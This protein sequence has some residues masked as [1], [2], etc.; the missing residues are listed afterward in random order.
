MTKG[1]KRY[2]DYISLIRRYDRDELLY[3]LSQSC[4]GW[5]GSPFEE[6]AETVA[7]EV[8]PWNVAGAAA[9]AITRGTRGGKRPTLTDVKRI[10]HEFSRIQTP[11]QL[12]E[13]QGTFGL[14]LRWAYEQWPYNRISK[15]D[16]ARCVALFVDTDLPI[17]YTPEAMKPGWQ[18]ELFGTTIETFVSVGAILW[19]ATNRGSR[20]PFPWSDEL[21]RMRDL[22]GGQK[23]FD[24]VVV[25]NFATDISG[26]KKARIAA[27]AQG[28][29][30]PGSQ[31]IREPFAYNPLLATPL[32]GGVLPGEWIAPCPPALNLKVSPAGIVYAGVAK[33]STG[34]FHDLGY[35]FEQYIG[36]QLRQGK[37]FVVRPEITYGKEEKKTI[38]WF[39]VTP[40]AVFLIECKSVLPSQA[41]KEGL[42]AHE[43]AHEQ[44][45]MKGVR[46]L[47]ATYSLVAKRHPA[48]QFLPRD[49]PI[50]GLLVTLGMFD[51][52]D[53]NFVKD[54]LPPADFP[55]AIVPS[56]FVESVATT[57][58]E[59]LAA[60]VGSASEF[61]DPRNF[62]AHRDWQEGRSHGPNAILEDAYDRLV[63]VSF[64]QEH[65]IDT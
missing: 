45:L 36:R 6:D 30:S 12:D 22:L 50:I 1:L 21:A 35:L 49:R 7:K 65:G 40:E 56:H 48:V 33:W 54:L 5:D 44:A 29:D 14:M 60:L 52:V 46:Q 27:L 24:A 25:R 16:W 63:I 57:E 42:Y 62:I 34:F 2:Q 39:V 41:I 20:F 31:F 15:H 37:D 8:L 4:L 47:N 59:E 43:E 18:E 55:L 3:G 64:A 58:R 9:V 53:Q 32:V 38:D 11:Q 51:L 26:F 10:T 28:K 17:N 13:L 61:T 19:A 23:Q